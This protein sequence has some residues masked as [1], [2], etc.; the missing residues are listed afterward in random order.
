MTTRPIRII[1]ISAASAAAL[2]QF[3]MVTPAQA[4][5]QQVFVNTTCSGWGPLQKC[6]NHFRTVCQNVAPPVAVLRPG[7]PAVANN[8]A[9]AAASRNGAG[10]LGNSSSGLIH[11]DGSGLI[12]HGGSTLR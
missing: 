1:A 3:A 8:A 10:I 11:Q 9:A 5:C 12:G 4:A 7:M 6:T 2:L